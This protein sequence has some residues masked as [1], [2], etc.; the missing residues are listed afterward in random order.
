MKTLWYDAH[1]GLRGLL[2]RPGF[3]AIIIA[4]VAL[5]VGANTAL[6]TVVNAV[7]IRQ[8]GFRE[9]DRVVA[10][11]QQ[12]PYSTVSEP[13]FEDYRRDARSLRQLAAYGVADVTLTGVDEPQRV[14]ILRTSDDFFDALGVAPA[15]GRAFTVDEARRG[16]PPV[17]MVSHGLWQRRFGGDPHL[18]GKTLTLN[19]TV[20]TIVGVMPSGFDFP[21]PD[22][23]AWVPLRLNP[24]S[25]WTRNNHYLNVVGRLAPH[26]SLGEAQAEVATLAQRFTHDF[27]NTYAHDKP[28][29]TAVRTVRDTVV[30]DTWPYL[31]ALLGAV[32]FVLLIACVNVANLLLVR[33]E[34][35]R[36][37][38]AV[39][40]AMGA[41]PRRLARQLLTESAMLALGGGALGLAL[42]WAGVHAF[43][44]AAPNSIPR[45]DGV[46]VDLVVLVFTLAITVL[47]GVLFGILPAV[48]GPEGPPAAMLGVG[49]RVSS[50]RSQR[51][52][53]RVLIAAEVALAVVTLAGAGLLVQSLLRLR[54]TDLGFDAAHVLTMQVTLSPKYYTGDFAPVQFYRTLLG[55]IT[56]THGVRA[57][58]AIGDLPMSGDN[59]A[60]SIM[61][62]GL[63]PHSISEAPSAKPEQVTPDY[64]RAMS[65]PMVRGRAFAE[66]DRPGGSPVVVVNETMAR[67]LWPDRDPIGHTIKMFSDSAPWVTVVGVAKDVRSN[68]GDQDV[69]PTMYFPYAQAGTS[70]YYTPLEMTLVVKT[71]SDPLALAPDFRRAVH[72][73]DPVAPIS[74]LQSM[75]AVVGSSLANRRF[76]TTL[77]AAFA[78]LALLLAGIG[79]YGVIAFGVSERTFEMGLRQ[80]LGAERHS[81]LILVVT[82]GVRMTLIGLAMGLLGALAAGRL[83][84]S[85]LVGTSP[86]DAPTLVLVS[87]ML[88]LVA[89]LASVV[90]AWRAMSVHPTEALRSG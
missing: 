60:W 12:P 37:E 63:M 59:S 54:A 72:D 40:T 57:A 33:G 32:G 87:V 53:G 28:L 7:L 64:F 51:T 61:V 34:A 50:L 65:I 88:I 20:C 73:L 14:S 46:R 78:M 19:G 75:D 79:I 31:I 84:R 26:A 66:T 4:T 10:L 23:D 90:P 17:V 21:S 58:A 43:V 49:G 56:G 70:A 15:L 62:D 81:L 16:G 89:I 6:F 44:A 86:S 55:R 25:L 47:T 29:I 76:A 52:T 71:A 35:R 3:T 80:A 36:R 83:I 38:L 8:M 74:S 82:E 42:G 1:H 30:G 39:R 48:R 45:L 77:L 2:R 9:P 13:E 68:G 69:P 27:P 18:V 5:G 67:E 24:D 41:S 11:E 85:L 22:I